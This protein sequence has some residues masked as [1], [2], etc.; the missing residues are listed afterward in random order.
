MEAGRK[1]L[2]KT[3]KFRKCIENTQDKYFKSI[4]NTNY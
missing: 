3:N 1:V 4:E 2:I